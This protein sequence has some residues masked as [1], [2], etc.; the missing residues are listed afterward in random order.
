MRALALTLLLSAPAFGQDTTCGAAAGGVVG[1][2][3][4]GR[5]WD[6]STPGPYAVTP[7]PALSVRCAQ[8]PTG[9]WI[10]V[11]TTP[12][13]RHTY[14]KLDGRGPLPIT[15]AIGMQ[16]GGP[17]ATFGPF[18]TTNGAAHGFG[19]RMERPLAETWLPTD[20]W[21]HPTLDLRVARMGG[22]DAQYQA[23]AM[24]EF[25]SNDP[26]GDR[27]WTSVFTEVA[28]HRG[29][30]IGTVT[31][32]RMT[33]REAPA[34]EGEALPL[35]L[36]V[37]VGVLTDL[38]RGRALE[39]IA[40]ATVDVQT[41]GNNSLSASAGGVLRDGEVVPVVGLSRHSSDQGADTL[42]LNTGVLAGRHNGENWLALDVGV[43]LMW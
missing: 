41:L 2:S 38:P 28:V 43:S 17:Y 25:H 6:L 16:I 23:W 35:A 19:L 3:P 24:I 13:L 27:G 32:Y 21:L 39:P 10:G 30:E 9:A 40:M 31:G 22:R 26:L 18:Y 36:G 4:A 37:R 15:G 11:D 12:L 7:S 34:L 33:L 1:V 42:S 29:F 20:S 5:D 14:S 8:R